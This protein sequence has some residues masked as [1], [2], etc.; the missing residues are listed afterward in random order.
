ML[1]DMRE[2]LVLKRISH[3]ARNSFKLCSFSTIF[4][5]NDL[6][7]NDIQDMSSCEQPVPQPI[8]HKRVIFHSYAYIHVKLKSFLQNF[9]Y[10]LPVS[11]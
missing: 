7:L 9:F 4:Y 5:L 3:V 11:V 8:G 6:T 10:Q 2:F 1:S